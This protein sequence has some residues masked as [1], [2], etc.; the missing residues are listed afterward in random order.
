MFISPG[1]SVSV[2]QPYNNTTTHTLI[3]LLRKVPSALALYI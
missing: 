3:N 1:K 2:K